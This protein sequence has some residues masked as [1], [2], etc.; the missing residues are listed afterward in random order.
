M[1][2]L[3]DTH[4]ALWWLSDHERLS[5]EQFD[6]IYSKNSQIILSAASIWEIRIKE[7][8]GKLEVPSNILEI[9]KEEN[10]EFLPITAQH[11]NHTRTLPPL[12]KDPFDRIIIAQAKLEG[13]TL[14]S[15]DQ[16]FS[17]YDVE[18]IR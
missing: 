11:A 15:S 14:I 7:S 17:G 13:L 18:I 3:L 9:I 5:K 2:A 10:I 12:H 8:L 6:F 16:A 1:R 4:I